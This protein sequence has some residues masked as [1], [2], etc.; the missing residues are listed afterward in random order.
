MKKDADYY[1]GLDYPLAV[2]PY[3]DDYFDG[4]RAFF[5]D[6]PAIESIGETQEEVLADLKDVKKEWFQYAVQK[7]ITIPEPHEIYP[8][9]ESCSGRV[10]L[11]LSKS[12]HRQVVAGAQNDGVT[13]NS[14]LNQLIQKGLHAQD[15]D[16]IVQQIQ[17][18]KEFIK[19]AEPPR[20]NTRTRRDF[21]FN[22]SYESFTTMTPIRQKSTQKN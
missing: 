22:R 6:I 9:E 13:L 20:S 14:Y 7:E 3:H 18:L 4:Y 15:N 19:A 12:L 10:T 21:E 8:K 1:L 17:Q 2:V 11:R 5:L 16:E